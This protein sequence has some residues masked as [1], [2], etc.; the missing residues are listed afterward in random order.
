[1]IGLTWLRLN[2]QLVQDFFHQQYLPPFPGI[3]ACITKR[4]LM[5]FI[6]L[7][8]LQFPPFWGYNIVSKLRRLTR[9]EFRWQTYTWPGEKWEKMSFWKPLLPSS[10]CE[11]IPVGTTLDSE[12]DTVI[13]LYRSSL[14]IAIVPKLHYLLLGGPSQLVSS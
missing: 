5:V 4:G 13:A 12:D 2:Y 10:N 7:V 1:M 3:F 11:I 6:I 14:I 8:M 9:I